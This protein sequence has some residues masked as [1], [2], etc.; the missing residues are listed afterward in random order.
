MGLACWKELGSVG[1]QQG[2]IDCGGARG[3]GSLC[4]DL[5]ALSIW[6]ALGQGR[7]SVCMAPEADSLGLW[8][9]TMTFQ[10]HIH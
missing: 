4:R 2:F 6:A 8:V 7:A 5:Q 3:A 10:G 9:Y 1:P